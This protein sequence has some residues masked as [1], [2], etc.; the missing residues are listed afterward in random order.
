MTNAEMIRNMT[1]KEL[2][3]FLNKRGF[4]PHTDGCKYYQGCKKC[5]KQYLG[6][7]AKVH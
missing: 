7:E 3:K 5:L 6:E 4:C 2:Y 1:D